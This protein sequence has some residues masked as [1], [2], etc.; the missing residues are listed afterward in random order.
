MEN[1]VEKAVDLFKE[2]YN[3]SQSVFAVY[4]E[5][6]SVDK[7]LALRL[8]SPFGGD[9]RSMWSCV[10]N[11]SACQLAQRYTCA[12]RQRSEKGKLRNSSIIVEQI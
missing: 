9:M 4:A 1:R 11:D 2:G 10:G 3:C 8:S 12:Q 6:F 7:E 5:L